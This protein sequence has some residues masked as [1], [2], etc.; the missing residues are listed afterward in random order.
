VNWQN[1]AIATWKTHVDPGALFFQQT[2]VF[3][4]EIGLFSMS[5]AIVS[6]SR[7]ASDD[8]TAMPR[9]GY[10]DFCAR[11]LRLIPCL[12]I[13]SSSKNLFMKNAK[14]LPAGDTACL[15]PARRE[16]VARQGR[17][18]V[19]FSRCR[20]ESGGGDQETEN[21]CGEKSPK[22]MMPSPGPAGPPSPAE[23]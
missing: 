7:Q 1:A 8:T 6:L 12:F 19:V 16:R 11:L 23:H 20:K 15:P 21:S 3:R 13:T 17:E 5:L 18:G 9:W 10:V 14:K 4:V 22:R 2:P